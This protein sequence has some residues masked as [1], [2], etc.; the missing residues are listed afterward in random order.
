MA[1]AM[2][3]RFRWRK[4]S[5]NS[6]AV[7]SPLRKHCRPYF[8]RA[9]LIEKYNLK[10][11]SYTVKNY[12]YITDRDLAERV[13]KVLNVQGHCVIE[14]SPGPG[15]LT[16]AMIDSGAKQVIGLEPDKIFME[17]LRSLQSETNGKFTPLFGDFGKIDPHLVHDE[18]DTKARICRAPAI[19]SKDLFKGI[20]P[21]EWESDETPVKFVGI[22]GGKTLASTTK[23]L[24]SYLARVPGKESIFKIGRC[25]LLF[26]YTHDRAERLLA[27]PGT[28]YYNRLSIMA[29]LFCDVNVIHR[30]PC[31]MF[32]PYFRKD[33]KK[34]LQ[35]ISIVP[36][37]RLDFSIP[38]D[39]LHLV[40]YF[41][42]IL[43]IKPKQS[44]A[45]SLDGIS[46]GSHVI[47]DNLGLPHDTRASDLVPK[48]YG[49]LLE[50]FFQWNE[51]S[52]EF[53]YS[54]S[55]RY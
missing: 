2:W 25:E 45:T 23:I 36:K 5:N 37:K 31:Q 9:T 20:S 21:V 13:A 10:P 43:M 14:A 28:K 18:S 6:L 1:T 38:E 11:R 39:C 46:P 19:A 53:F 33:G 29:S 15:M 34:E 32:D 7:F 55:S 27:Q 30:E 42:R 48:M 12:K 3:L 22:E 51:R 49:R 35:L 54:M 40:G 16:R 50:Q 26:F 8:S 47:L 17:D 41:I 24:M 44:L 4:I 52:L